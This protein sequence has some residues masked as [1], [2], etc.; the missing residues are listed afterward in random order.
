M[1]RP[2]DSFLSRTL[3]RA[4]ERKN[5]YLCSV[6][7][8]VDNRSSN[9]RERIRPAAASTSLKKYY[10]KKKSRQHVAAVEPQISAQ[11]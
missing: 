2:T 10:I 11:V 6:L 3:I 7:F 5:I 8:L 9:I 1:C 4:K